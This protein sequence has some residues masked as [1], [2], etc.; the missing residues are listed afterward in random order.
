MLSE[1]EK[2]ERKRVS[3]QKY[4]QNNKDKIKEY[5]ESHR[6]VQKRAEE[7]RKNCPIRK[8]YKR[9]LNKQPHIIKKRR[10]RTWIRSGVINEDFDSLYEHFINT[11]NCELCNVVLEGNG[12]Q[13]KCLDHDH[14]TGLFRNVLC[15]V[16]N[17]VYMRVVK[18]HRI[19]IEERDKRLKE[20][21]EAK[22]VKYTCECGSII[23]KAE[24]SKHIKTKKHNK[25]LLDN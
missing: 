23:S 24:K 14:S 10:I 3:N 22:K 16:C 7:K 8:E 21:I 1:E 17:W 25:F 5:I 13:K 6:D 11:N 4:Y 9:N 12:K 18:K 19:S 15:N 2:K 20:R